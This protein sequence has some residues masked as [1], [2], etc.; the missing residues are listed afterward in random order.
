ME[1]RE[2]EMDLKVTSVL[3]PN[4]ELSYDSYLGF[5]CWS[6]TVISTLGT[7]IKIQIGSSFEQGSEPLD[8]LQKEID[9]ARMWKHGS[10]F[11]E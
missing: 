6:L 8:K 3:S 7:R 5:N 10:K 2:R 1:G 11:Q 9:L 4:F